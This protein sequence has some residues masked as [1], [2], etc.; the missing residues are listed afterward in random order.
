[1]AKP[2]SNINLRTIRSESNRILSADFRHFNALVFLFLSPISSTLIYCQ[3]Y[4]IKTLISNLLYTL[5]ISVLSLFAAGSVTYSVF[6]RFHGR[7]VKLSSSVKAAFTSFFPLLSTWL[8]T[9]LIISGIG[10]VLGLAFFSLFKVT[11]LLGLQVDYPSSY[12]TLLCLVHVIILMFIV[13]YLQ[14]NWIFAYLIVV[15]ESSW[16][17]EPLKRSQIL[18]KGMKGVAFKIVLVLSIF[19]WLGAWSSMLRW[20]VFAGDTLKIWT[21]LIQIVTL[22]ASSYYMLFSFYNLVVNSVFYM[23]SK[24]RHGELAQEC[25][26]LTTFDD[27]KVPDRVV[28]NV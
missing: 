22:P 20:V 18:V 3:I 6:H 17:L 2:P 19:C 10:L 13:V 5:T 12:F 11:Q 14:V 16:G 21:F 8:V 23:Y 1:M 26:S 27:G 25:V 24:A 28:S 15:V 4:P 9:Q 7:P